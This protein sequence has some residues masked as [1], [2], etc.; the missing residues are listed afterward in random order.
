LTRMEPVARGKVMVG[1]GSTGPEVKQDARP[2][3][4]TR[5]RPFACHGQRMLRAFDVRWPLRRSSCRYG[6]YWPSCGQSHS[7]W[8]PLGRAHS[9]RVSAAPRRRRSHDA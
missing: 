3:E 8:C 7:H 6:P 9:F 4:G 2:N 1:P 5:M